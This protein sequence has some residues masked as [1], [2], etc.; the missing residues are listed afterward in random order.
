ISVCDYDDVS[1]E[2]SAC[3]CQSSPGTAELCHAL[4]RNLSLP[5]CKWECT[6]GHKQN[7]VKC[8]SDKMRLDLRVTLFFHFRV[9]QDRGCVNE[10][11][12]HGL[13]C[14]KRVRWSSCE[15]ARRTYRRLD[16]AKRRQRLSTLFC[17]IATHSVTRQFF[18]H[19]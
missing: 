10:P 4:L 5:Q 7:Y 16:F 9:G 19:S 2:R 8:A 6:H 17:R 13:L 14:G 3:F 12:V 18:S 15:D 1:W 11:F